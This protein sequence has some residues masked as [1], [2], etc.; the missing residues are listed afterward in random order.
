MDFARASDTFNVPA[1]FMDFWYDYGSEETTEMFNAFRENAQSKVS[2]SNQ[3]MIIGPSTHCGYTEATENTI[4][5]ER[6]LGDARLPWLDIQLRW[7]DCWLKGK[8]N[9]I[10]DRHG[11]F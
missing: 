9:G 1:L 11:S 10:N 4:V 2:E 6:E 7:Y 8:K 3:F 5:G